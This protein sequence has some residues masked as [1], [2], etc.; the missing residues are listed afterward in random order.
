MMGVIVIKRAWIIEGARHSA[1]P[2]FSDMGSEQMIA[3]PLLTRV[4]T[5]ATLA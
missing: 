4:V 2:L 1:A 3:K 5:E